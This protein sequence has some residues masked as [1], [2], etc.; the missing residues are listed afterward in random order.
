MIRNWVHRLTLVA[1]FC[2]GFS[3]HAVAAGG[4]T[5]VYPNATNKNP[6]LPIGSPMFQLETADAAATVDAWYGAHLPKG[7]THQTAQGGAKYACPG[8]NIMIT[9]NGGKTLITHMSPMGGMLGH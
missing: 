7:C 9:P 1:L 6:E 8:I 4:G 3:L 2:A 5:P